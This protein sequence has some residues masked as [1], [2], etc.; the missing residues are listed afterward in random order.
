MKVSVIIRTYNA[1]DSIKKALESVSNQDFSKKHFEII[2]INDGSTDGTSEIL[3]SYQKQ[4]RLIN[5]KNRGAVPSA[6][7]GFRMAKGKYL[8]LL[9]ADDYFAPTILK[10]MADI[11]DKKPEIDFVCCDYYEKSKNGKVKIVSTKNI[12]NILACGVMYRKNKFAKERFYKENLKLPEY[13]LLLQTKKK[14]QG[15]HIPK[16]LYFYNR[17][18]DSLSGEKQWVKS[19]IN[20]LKKIHPQ[21]IELIEKI[22]KF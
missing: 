11:L 15:Y 2:V 18:K 21:K 14:W 12:F 20:E 9:D 17:R 13:D 3:E 1:Q 8:I 16:P 22:R 19:A 7:R 5:Q 4:I 6:N 10:K